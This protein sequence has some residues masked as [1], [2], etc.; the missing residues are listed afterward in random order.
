MLFL[1]RPLTYSLGYQGLRGTNAAGFAN[2]NRKRAAS[3]RSSHTI[4]IHGIILAKRR[5]G[6]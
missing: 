1:H 4:Y 5:C 2:R 3:F 6:R